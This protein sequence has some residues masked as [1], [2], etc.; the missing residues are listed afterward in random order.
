MVAIEQGGTT[1][2]AIDGGNKTINSMSNNV[3]ILSKQIGFRGRKSW[4][5]RIY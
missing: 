4:R 1:E 2:M 5:I 3:V